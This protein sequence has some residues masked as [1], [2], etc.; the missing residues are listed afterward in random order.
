MS[1][2]TDLHNAVKHG[3]LDSIRRLLKADRILA[4]SRSETDARGTFPLHVA[5]EPENLN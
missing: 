5:A 4:N 2:V 1:A 3:D